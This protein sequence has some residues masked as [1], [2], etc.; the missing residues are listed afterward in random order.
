VPDRIEPSIVPWHSG[1]MDSDPMSVGVM[2]KAT[3]DYKGI[4]RAGLPSAGET[5]KING[6]NGCMPVRTKTYKKQRHHW[7]KTFDLTQSE[8]LHPKLCLESLTVASLNVT[9]RHLLSISFSFWCGLVGDVDHRRKPRKH[10]EY[11]C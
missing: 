5:A 8:G 10:D 1:R 9:E 4:D 7:V 3:W 2:W 6:E 11:K